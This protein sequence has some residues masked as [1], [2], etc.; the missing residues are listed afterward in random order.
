[1]LVIPEKFN[2][3]NPAIRAMGPP[4]ETGL[5]LI[6]HMCERIGISSLAEL[7]V[8]D[9]G[10]GSRFTDA[11]VNR[12][13]QLNSYIGI[14]VYK[15]MID[16]LTE[17]VDDPRL[18]FLH[19]DVHNLQ[20]N[21]GGVPLVE[22]TDLP[23]GERKFDIVCMYSVITHQLPHDTAIIFKLL[24]RRVKEDGHLF[25]SAAVE[26][27]DFGYREQYPDAPTALSVY[28][29]DLMTKLLDAARWRVLSFAKRVPGGLPNQET[30][31]CAPI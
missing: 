16:F 5:R 2:R 26:E 15:E 30:I 9:F 17:H 3:N 12:N 23:V 18:C 20:Y 8:L 4:A 19:V 1:V 13:I 14:D 27:G 11:I 10:C 6:N 29:L 28:S 22:S 7:D 25:F 31:L 24:R 21:P